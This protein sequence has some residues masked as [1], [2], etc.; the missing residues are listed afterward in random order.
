VEKA[1][2]VET[3]PAKTIPVEKADV[4]KKEDNTVLK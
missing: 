4:L 1:A 2:P 3:K